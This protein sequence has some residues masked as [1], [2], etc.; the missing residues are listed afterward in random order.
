M[1]CAQSA[2]RVAPKSGAAG[3]AVTEVA[4]R[5]A[6]YNDSGFHAFLS[7]Y[8]VEAATEAR[9]LQ[10]QLEPKL[11]GRAFLDSDDLN[12]LSKL[13]Q[14]VRDSKCLLLLQ[15]R[16]VLTRPWCLLEL[17]TAIDEG[18]PIVG[19]SIVSGAS[20]Y[21]FAQAGSLMAHLDTLLPDGKAQD[22]EALG[23]D[24]L[25]AAYKLSNTIPNIISVSLNMNQSRGMLA[26]TVN[27]IIEAMGKA[28]L[29]ECQ[30][31]TSGSLRA[32]SRRP[33]M[34]SRPRMTS[35]RVRRQSRQSLP[36]FQMRCR[37]CPPP[38]SCGTSS[39][40]RSRR[41]CSIGRLLHLPP[42][43]S[44]HRHA[45]FAPTAYTRPRRAA[46]AAW[47][48]LSLPLRSAGI[49]TSAAP[50]RPSAG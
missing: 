16:S 8:K 4:Q 37:T 20:P 3:G 35:C 2:E 5:R 18:V 32:A 27:D 28:V 48:R 44:R 14:H 6:S 15:T 19:V 47:A 22:A 30:T 26:A 33:R 11:D 42:R 25:D 34:A 50:S 36:T 13:T 31:K 17:K 40:R 23:I 1:G 29:P 39:T 43:R 9:W 10:E 45:P 49:Q 38:S 7:H 46:W 21:D 24:V 12:D 41:A